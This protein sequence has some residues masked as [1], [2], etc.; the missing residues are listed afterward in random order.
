MVIEQAVMQAFT[1][2]CEYMYTGKIETLEDAEVAINVWMVA[3]SLLI[4]DLPKYALRRIMEILPS[5][6]IHIIPGIFRQAFAA[7]QLSKGTGM[8]HTGTH[9]DEEGASILQAVMEFILC[10]LQVSHAAASHLPAC[11]THS[12]MHCASFGSPLQHATRSGLNERNRARM[13][14]ISYAKATCACS[15]T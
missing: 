15:L 12:C 5:S 9:A 7:W 14:M 4:R 6:H 13:D 11:I 8:S 10:K 3:S 1:L 2:A